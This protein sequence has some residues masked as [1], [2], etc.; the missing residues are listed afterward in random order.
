MNCPL[1]R[2]TGKMLFSQEWCQNDSVCFNVKGRLLRIS[3]ASHKKGFLMEKILF[4]LEAVLSILIECYRRND[5]SET[6]GILVGP[7]NHKRIVTDVIPS[8]DYAE[9]SPVAYYRSEKDSE[10]LNHKLE[11]FHKIYYDYKGDFHKHPFGMRYFSHIDT[12]T[13]YDILKNPCYSI[14]NFLIMCIITNTPNEDFPLFCYTV[15]LDNNENIQIN[16]ASIKVLPKTCIQECMDCF[17]QGEEGYESNNPK[18]H[19]GIFKIPESSNTVRISGAGESDNKLSG[20]KAW[21]KGSRNIFSKIK[22]YFRGFAE[23]ICNC[24]HK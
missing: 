15:S 5:N 9:I 20:K 6:G 24:F 14:D 18:Q 23:R 4:S 22:R 17:E 21:F 16:K 10:F 8:S 7:K 12:D 2:T 19:L 3:A 1:P 13:C 11:K